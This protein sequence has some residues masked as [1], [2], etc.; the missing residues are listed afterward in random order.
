MRGSWSD[1]LLFL[2]KGT[3]PGAGGRA[4]AGSGLRASAPLSAMREQPTAPGLP[5]KATALRA[6]RHR[7][8]KAG[9]GR[10]WP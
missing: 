1:L 2:G 5:Q 3:Y 4:I 6:R 8:A 7:E 10:Q 9:M